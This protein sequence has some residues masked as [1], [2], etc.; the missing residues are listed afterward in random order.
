M[1]AATEALEG[2]VQHL[3]ETQGR[4][5][6]AEALR[7]ALARLEAAGQPA[8]AAPDPAPSAGPV[9][10]EC[11]R[12]VTG[13]IG[14]TPLVQLDPSRLGFD[15]CAPG[16]RVLAKL[17]FQNPGGSVKDRIALQMI[18][19][20][21]RAG[22]IQPGVTTLVEATSGNTGIALAMVAASRGYRLIVT[23]SRLH[24]MTERY[25]LIR[26]FGAEVAL[27]EPELKAQGFID[28]AAKI[29]RDTPN[30]VLMSQFTNEENPQAHY[31]GTGPEILEQTGGQVDVLV[32]GAG[33]GGTIV[34]TGRYLKEQKPAVQVVM[35]EPASSRVFQGA[36]HRVHSLVGIGTGLHV[37][38]IDELAPG[39]SYTEGEGRGLIDE[40]MSAADGASL[41]MALCMGREQGLLVGPTSG[42]AVI[43]ACELASRPENQNKTIV[44]I[45]ASSAVRYIQHP[46]FKAL[47]D[48][49]SSALASSTD[50]LVQPP[51]AR[52]IAN[53]TNIGGMD[54][55]AL[56]TAA[57][58]SSSVSQEEES[59]ELLVEGV[60]KAVLALTR[61]VLNVPTLQPSDTLVDFG[62]TSL[63][64][65][66]LLGQ[67]RQTLEP[68]LVPSE[69]K[70]HGLKLAMMKEA[71]W[72]T[73]RELS[74]QVLGLDGACVALPSSATLHREIAIT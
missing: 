72:G 42:A 6:A 32:A 21:E 69:T 3:V 70:L 39:Q 64:A 48:E 61:R 29:A 74:H 20:A 38:M 37:P 28:L 65:M 16:V 1:A 17:E 51:P 2:L 4:K 22:K 15:S 47:R 62:A 73:T 41:D 5:A 60:E 7:A 10:F 31:V 67:L 59:R 71:L 35:V 13:A 14:R 40:F 43:C 68:V 36:K 33:T 34:G 44:A 63:T 19:A 49:A 27:A 46:M 30:S 50:V 55:A 18:E 26:A 25:I 9:P 12:D 23:M 45:C 54:E 66:M 11:L 57:G 52:I 24:A 56:P 53:N 58:S 8:P